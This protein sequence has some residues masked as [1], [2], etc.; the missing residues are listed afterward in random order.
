MILQHHGR[1]LARQ[2][3]SLQIIIFDQISGLHIHS[4]CEQGFSEL[5]NVINVV[6]P[7]LDRAGGR[8][9]WLNLGGDI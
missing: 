9:S 5:A 7:L 3:V 2:L 1:V 4:L 6:K 8:L